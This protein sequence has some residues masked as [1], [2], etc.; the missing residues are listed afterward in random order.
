MVNKIIKNKNSFIYELQC[1]LIEDDERFVIKGNL[2]KDDI[3][4]LIFYLQV[5]F[6]NILDRAILIPYDISN[7]LTKLYGFEEVE[8][9]ENIS[10]DQ[11]IELTNNIDENIDKIDKILENK[12]N[13][14]VDGLYDML[15][16]IKLEIVQDNPNVFEEEYLKLQNK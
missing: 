4:E 7:I 16:D 5:E 10:I 11:T 6:R 2:D 8:N 3:N 12:S 9:V 1:D 14:Y 15:E 13:L